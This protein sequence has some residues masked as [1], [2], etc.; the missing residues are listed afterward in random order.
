MLK[1]VLVVLLILMVSAVVLA[2]DDLTATT[3][4]ELNMRDA[5][6]QGGG[7]IVKLPQG[8][9]VVVEGR[10]ST[11]AW[12]LVHTPD[13]VWRSPGLISACL[14]PPVKAERHLCRSSPTSEL[15]IPRSG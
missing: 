5:P 9:T 11:S 10:D 12:L 14:T 2:Q 7:V 3:L 6:N 15:T 13:T 8:T 4:V 1:K